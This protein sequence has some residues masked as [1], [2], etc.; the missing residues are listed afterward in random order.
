M[1]KIYDEP[2]AVRTEEAGKPVRFTWRGRRYGIKECFSTWRERHSWWKKQGET[3]KLY[4]RVETDRGGLYD[5][6]FDVKEH[7]WRMYRVWD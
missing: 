4:M 1:S 7:R 5:L 2:I 6:C 3:N